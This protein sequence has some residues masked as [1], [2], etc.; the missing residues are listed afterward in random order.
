MTLVST[1]EFMNPK[2]LLWVF[3]VTGGCSLVFRGSGARAVLSFFLALFLA[4]CFCE[5]MNVSFQ[6]PVI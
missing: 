6:D 3:V 2:F 1:A 5:F 4:A